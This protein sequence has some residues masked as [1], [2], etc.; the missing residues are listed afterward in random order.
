MNPH[1]PEFVP[2]KAR[3]TSAATEDSRVAI[4]A[5]SSTGLNN[6]VTIVS[7]EEKLDKKAT[8]DVR[9]ARS[10]KSRLHAE[11]EELARQIQNSFIVKS[12]QN[13]SDGP[14]EFPVSTKKSEFLVS[15]AKASADDSAIKLQC[16]S[17][18]KKEV[19]TEANKYSGAKTVDVNKNKH[20]DGDG[21]LPVI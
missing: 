10:T 12:K 21:F 2:S 11:R 14:S 4:D 13:T 18:G 3:P 9:N 1:A 7:A 19:L 16:G 6:S 15:A 8:I 17:E 20:E 5:D